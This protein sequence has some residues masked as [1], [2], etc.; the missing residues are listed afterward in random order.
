MHRRTVL[1][2][3][4]ST[5]LMPVLGSVPV[6]KADRQAILILI[7]LKGG[8]DGLNTVVPYR[9]PLYKKYRP[10]IAL[11]K[12]ELLPI[13][14]ELALHPAMQQFMDLWNSSELAIVQNVGYPNPNL[15]HFRGIDI[16]QTASGSQNTQHKGWI[17]ES[18]GKH[19][20]KKRS[21]ISLA[22]SSKLFSGGD[23]NYLHI[24]NPDRFIVRAGKLKS[25]HSDENSAALRHWLA[26]QDNVK[27]QG[28]L[29]GDLFKQGSYMETVFP[30]ST[31]GR[32]CQLATQIVVR[33]SPVQ[34]IKLMIAGFDTH[35][36]QGRQHATL[37]KQLAEGLNALKQGLREVGLWENTLIMTYSEFGRRVKENG[38]EGTDHGAAAPLFLM[39]GRVNGGLYGT[40]PNLGDVDRRGNLKFKIDYRRIYSTVIQ[41]WWGITKEQPL[42]AFKP[43]DFLA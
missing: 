40:D 35:R 4:L 20:T 17:N 24:R 9:D 19:Q 18:L 42:A 21:A 23:L 22:G 11:A 3:L 43:L 26:I 37:L 30:A 14:D 12:K 34:C 29:L 38:N 1:T 15:S 10:T 41:N 16:W 31:F 7:E 27:V 13:S 25:W 2:A 6:S 39:G 33:G 36:L 28:S 5:P 8:N 32:Q